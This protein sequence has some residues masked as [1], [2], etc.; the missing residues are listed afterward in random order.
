MGLMDMARSRA[1]GRRVAEHAPVGMQARAA[2]ID[3]SGRMGYNCV[4]MASLRW[5]KILHRAD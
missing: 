5:T 2:D 1:R 4:E 3:T